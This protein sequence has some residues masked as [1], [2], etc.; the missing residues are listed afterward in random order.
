MDFSNSRELLKKLFLRGLKACSPQRVV[1]QSMEFSGD[2]I[3]IIGKD[4]AADE[5]PI[6][7]WATG[8]ASV[9]MYEQIAKILGNRINKSLVITSDSNQANVCR[10]DEVIVGSHP[11]PNQDSVEAGERVMAFMRSV[12]DNAIV[13]SLISGGTSSLLCQPAD[14]ISIGDLSRTFKLLNHSGAT[15]YEINTVRKHCSKIKGGQL[16]RYLRSNITLRDLIISD[17]PNDQLSIIGSG[18]TVADESTYQ[19]AYHILSEYGLWEGVS[20]SIRTHIRK[21]MQGKAEETIKP[22]NDPISDHQSEVIGSAR[23]L[24][25]QIKDIAMS[26]GVDVFLA[27]KPFNDDVEIVANTITD[28]VLRDLDHDKSKKVLLYIFWGESTVQVT[29]D[30][31]GGCNQELALWA[32]RKIAGYENITWLS[33]GTDGIDGPTDAAG[34]IVDGKTLDE[35]KDKGLDAGEYLINN[36]SYHFHQQ[37]DTHLKTGPTGNNLMDVVLVSR[38]L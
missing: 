1:E 28:K 32:A 13:I 12:P 20:K 34:A 23:L 4:I 27:D 3:T 15:I 9:P 30:G 5:R 24:G 7:V 18:P 29:G 21:G 6:Y 35:A 38:E 31:K 14:E 19:D 16:L 10:A 8:K 37:M 26:K 33:A 22:G 36:D 17:V 2:T 25:Q 11:E